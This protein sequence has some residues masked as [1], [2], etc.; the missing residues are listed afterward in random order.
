MS[1]LEGFVLG[2]MCGATV[3]FLAVVTVWGAIR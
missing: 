2:L 1:A 3:G